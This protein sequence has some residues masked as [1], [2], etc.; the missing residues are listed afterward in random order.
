MRPICT[1]CVPSLVSRCSFADLTV[2]IQ[3]LDNV[4][5]EENQSLHQL[6]V[7]DAAFSLRHDDYRL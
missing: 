1:F 7:L 4:G 5:H 2:Q 6:A 3:T